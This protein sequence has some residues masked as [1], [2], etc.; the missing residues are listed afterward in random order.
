MPDPQGPTFAAPESQ[1]EPGADGEDYVFRFR[2]EPK[3]KEEAGYDDPLLELVRGQL[4]DLLDAVVLTFHGQRVRVDGF[5]LFQDPDTQHEI[6]PQ[7][8][9]QPAPGD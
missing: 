7:P 5:R 2:L 9:E 3:A 8:K 1:E 6:F 4:A